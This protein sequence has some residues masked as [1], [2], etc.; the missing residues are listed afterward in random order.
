MI[1]FQD[2][3]FSFVFLFVKNGKDMLHVLIYNKFG[4]EEGRLSSGISTGFRGGEPSSLGATFG[5]GIGGSID[6]VDRKALTTS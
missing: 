5:E 6:V 3:L 2:G 4:G 1:D